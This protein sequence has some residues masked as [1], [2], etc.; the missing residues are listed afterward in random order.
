MQEHKCAYCGGEAQ[1]QLKNGKWCCQEKFNKCPAI[2]EKN[3]SGLKKAYQTG[4]RDAKEIYQNK[5]QQSKRR[6]AWSKGKSK[7]DCE[8]LRIKGQLLSNRYKNGELT[9]SQL[10][11]KHTSQQIDKI[12]K[13][14]TGVQRKFINNPS[15]DG[16]KRGYY[17]KYWCDSSW[18]LAFILYNIDH[19]I[20]FERNDT[21]SITYTYKDKNRKF[22]PDFKMSD[23]TYVQIKGWVGE[24]NQIKLKAAKDELG[25]KFKVID[26]KE[27]NEIYLPYV[28]QTY[29]NNFYELYKKS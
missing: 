2:R 13:G 29:G 21:F 10:G 27:M 28:I 19:N 12:M 22:Y 24:Q 16:Y 23:G 7:F 26:K 3:S 9:P 4:T 15:K 25:D 8:I 14:M 20:Q 17:E 6:S 18:E 5:S 11:R 1:Y